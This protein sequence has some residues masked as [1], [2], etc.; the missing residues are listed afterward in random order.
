[1]GIEHGGKQ[2]Q[3]VGTA[4]AT[5]GF[6]LVDVPVQ[7]IVGV[8]PPLHAAVPST[9]RSGNRKKMVR[10][11]ILDQL[12]MLRSMNAATAPLIRPPAE[13]GVAGMVLLQRVMGLAELLQR[14]KPVGRKQVVNDMKHRSQARW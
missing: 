8:A 13:Q 14:I 7:I 6:V 9:E 3:N 4:A 5:L 2:G 1:M 12:Q 10:E 11:V